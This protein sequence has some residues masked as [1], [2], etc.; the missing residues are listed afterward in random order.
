[1]FT[2]P[3]GAT[4]KVLE[5]IDLEIRPR[6]VVCLLG[7]SG[8]GKSTLLRIFAGLIPASS[9]EVLYKNAPLVGLNPGVGMVF[10]AFALYPWLTVLENVR[11]PLEALGVA[12][13][14]A[15]ARALAAIKTVGLS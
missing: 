10:Q 13:A 1:E 4:L 3:G 11:A 7:P 12:A 8:C 5:G 9:G 15:N 6:E 2:P 14:E